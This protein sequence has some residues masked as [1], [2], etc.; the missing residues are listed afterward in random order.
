MKL[1]FEVESIPIDENYYLQRVEQKHV[2]GIYD[3]YSDPDTAKYLVS[4]EYTR[5]EEAYDYYR[6]TEEWFL[7]RQAIYYAMMYRNDMIGLAVIHSYQ[8]WGSYARAAIGYGVRKRYQRQGYAFF[9]VTNLMNTLF[10]HTNL[11]RIEATVNPENIPS[12]RLL[13]RIGFEKEGLLR[14]YSYNERTKC[15]EDRWMY[16]YI[17]TQS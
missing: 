9:F 16:S 3:L 4:R 8:Q 17:P 11:M 15:V 12:Q 7:N 5:L 14:N 1:L 6:K 13:E 2:A 10:Q